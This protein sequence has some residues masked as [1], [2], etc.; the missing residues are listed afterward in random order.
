M[1]VNHI[2]SDTLSEAKERARS[3]KPEEQSGRGFRQIK[4][5]DYF[6]P[7]EEEEKQRKKRKHISPSYRNKKKILVKL[8]L[9]LCFLQKV[10]V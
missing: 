8:I 10:L 7:T 5:T 2:I 9:I 6:S 3:G 4:P 1:N